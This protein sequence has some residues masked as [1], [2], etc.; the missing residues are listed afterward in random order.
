MSLVITRPPPRPT[1]DRSVKYYTIHSKPN[2]VFTLKMPYMKRT[3]VVSF[4]QINDALNIGKMIE[5]HYVH[6]RE[7]PDTRS[8]SFLLPSS[9]LGEKDLEHVYIQM[10]D[11]EE[12]KV[13]CTRN[14]LDMMSVD[15]I[16]TKNDST[17]SLAGSII[18]FDAP[19][20]FYRLRFEEL[21]TVSQEE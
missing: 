8:E 3:T 5:T 17:F 21:L 9:Q 18:T 13:E 11:F 1:L 16:V 15:E 4:K 7:W 19:D 10:W 2:D 6:K 20:D 14:I 12:L